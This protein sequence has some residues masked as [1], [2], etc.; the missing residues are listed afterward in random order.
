MTTVAKPAASRLIG[1]ASVWRYFNSNNTPLARNP[2]EV[3]VH[4]NDVRSGCSAGLGGDADAAD[5]RATLG[6]GRDAVMVES[7]QCA[8]PRP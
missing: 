8:P 1:G 4:A 7:R 2:S 6:Q 5:G 3:R